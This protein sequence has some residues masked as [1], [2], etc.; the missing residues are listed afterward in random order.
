MNMVAE[1][2]K[3]T[4]SVNQWAEKN[5]VEMPITRAVHKVLFENMDPIDALIELMT[6]NPKEEKMI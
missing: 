1:G 6:R 5:N 2:V 4:D 3:T